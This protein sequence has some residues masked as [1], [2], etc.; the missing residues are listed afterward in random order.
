MREQTL[1]FVLEAGASLWQKPAPYD[2]DREELVAV[3]W[4][5][6]IQYFFEFV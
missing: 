4:L 5:F 2:S 3:F 1:V 6:A